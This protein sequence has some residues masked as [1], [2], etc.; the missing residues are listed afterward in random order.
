MQ[1]NSDVSEVV[2]MRAKR[3][4]RKTILAGYTLCSCQEL[5]HD[6]DHAKEQ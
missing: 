2:Q 6:L 5:K 3:F 4:V 1:K